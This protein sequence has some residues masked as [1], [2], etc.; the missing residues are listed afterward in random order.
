MDL[1]I[2]LLIIFISLVPEDVF[3]A[4]PRL[5]GDLELLARAVSG[6]PQTGKRGRA[7]FQA[8]EGAPLLREKVEVKKWNAR[9]EEEEKRSAKRFSE[10]LRAVDLNLRNLSLTGIIVY[11]V[12][13]AVVPD[14]RHGQNQYKSFT[15]TAFPN[16]KKVLWRRQCK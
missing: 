12:L 7:V 6:R 9:I 13:Y 4:E 15:I 2:L 11:S 16:K 10:D 1:K 14:S 8:A 3:P 5:N